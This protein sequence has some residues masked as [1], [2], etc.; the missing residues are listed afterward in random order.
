MTSQEYLT[1]E[2]FNDNF[3]ALNLGAV[4][5][6]ANIEYLIEN[7]SASFDPFFTN[8]ELA[9]EFRVKIKQADFEKAEDL[10][11]QISLKEIETI[12]KDYYLFEFTDQE[13]MDVVAKKD[14]WGRLNFTLAQKILKDRGKEVRL[15]KVEKFQEQRIEELKQPE[16]GAGGMIVAGY[17]AAILGGLIGLFIGL[18]IVTHKKTL[19]NGEQVYGYSPADRKN[20]STILVLSI[21]FTLLWLVVRFAKF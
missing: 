14:E 1:F 2:L 6:E 8:N 12:D 13:L 10:L 21:F 11:Q 5:R 7:T 18:H 16:K 20:G 4:L 19:P 3:E 9:K 17:I 15:E